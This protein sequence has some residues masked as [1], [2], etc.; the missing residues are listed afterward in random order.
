MDNTRRY[1]RLCRSMRLNERMGTEHWSLAATLA[2]LVPL[3]ALIVGAIMVPAVRWI[4]LFWLLCYPIPFLPTHLIFKKLIADSQFRS[5]VNFGLR[6]LL[7]ILYAIVIG[8]VMA[9][10]GGGWMSRLLDIG[11]WWGVV[12]VGL[13]HIEAILAGP[14]VNA[15]KGI[16]RNL[17]YWLLR[18]FGGKKMSEMRSLLQK[19]TVLGD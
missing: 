8:I 19:I 9:C 16:G 18:L 15:L 5:S 7:S 14:T 2:S 6:F 10:T 1:Q 13:V 3:A 17:Q 11:A 12:A 4:L